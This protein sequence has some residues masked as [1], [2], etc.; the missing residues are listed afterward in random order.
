M[1]LLMPKLKGRWAPPS[2]GWKLRATGGALAG[3]AAGGLFQVRAQSFFNPYATPLPAYGSTL[4]SGEGAG[5]NFLINRGVPYS[6]TGTPAMHDYNMKFGPVTASLG[7]GLSTSYYDNYNLVPEGSGLK[8]EDELSITPTLS[9][10]FQ[11]P[12]AR[13]S[14]LHFDVGFG[15][16]VFL[17][18]PDQ[19]RF[20][21][22]PASAWDYQFK[23]G[24][25]RFTLVDHISSSGES[26]SQRTDL[27]GTGSASAVQ[28]RRLSNTIGLTA[29]WQPTRLYTVSGS[30]ALDFDHGLGDSFGLADHLTHTLSTAVFRRLNTHWTVGLSASAF[31]NEYLEGIQ[32]NSMGYGAGPTV[33]WQPSAFLNFSGSVRYNTAKSES[34]GTIGDRNGS[35][36]A[37]YDFTVQHVINRHLNHGLSLSSGIDLGVGVNFNDTVTLSYRLGWQISKAM[38]LN[39]N[40]SRAVTT[41]SGAGYDFF[42]IVPVRDPVTGNIV[43]FVTPDG[44]PISPSPGALIDL[45]SGLLLQPRPKEETEAYS[46]GLG[47]GFQLTRRL[48]ASVNYIHTLRLSNLP[49]HDYNQNTYTLSLGYRF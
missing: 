35:S 34:T 8:Q 44:Q 48:S 11:W 19:D 32:N 12:I 45:S 5:D 38:T 17:N 2:S 6:P 13:D 41:Q 15:Y 39:F 25:V 33:S 26:S 24:D 7:G 30:Y 22:S 28:F 16:A 3:L 42:K 46:F 1:N 23:V 47:T 49:L 43:G 4:S 29:A 27:T 21:I 40:A 37:G 10:A 18:H 14:T 20:T 31:R 9:L 36:G